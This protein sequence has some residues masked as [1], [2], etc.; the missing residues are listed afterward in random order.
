M[1]GYI[2][3]KILD[4]K[5]TQ[6]LIDVNGIGYIVNTSIITFEKLTEVGS[7]VS[8]FTYLVVKEDSLTLYGFYE[9]AEKELFEKLIGINGVG[10]KLAQGILSGITVDEFKSA[11]FENNISRLVSI[12][13]VGK[14]TAERMLVELRDKISSVSSTV[15]SENTVVFTIKDDAVAALTSLGYN[16]KTAEKIIREIFQNSSNLNLEELITEAL[17]KL[18]K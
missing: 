14:K 6:S 1:I 7:S 17:K 2:T 18:N 16:S 5:P 15:S 4:K 9:F 12:P 11:I 8:L 13:G 10:P 3:G